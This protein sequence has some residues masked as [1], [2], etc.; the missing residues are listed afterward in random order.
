MGLTAVSVSVIG[1]MIARAVLG[2]GEAGAFLL[3]LRLLQNIF[4]KKNGLLPLVFLI[5]VLT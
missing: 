4:L 5:Q 1:F 3:L 2:F